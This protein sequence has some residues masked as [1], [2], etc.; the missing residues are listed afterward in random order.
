MAF[1]SLYN[2]DLDV[3]CQD[4]RELVGHIPFCNDHTHVVTCQH[5]VTLDKGALNSLNTA[6]E[7]VVN[8][9]STFL[10]TS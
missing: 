5:M 6:I 7:S 8:S 2:R 1:P 9:W 10:E 3:G 4:D